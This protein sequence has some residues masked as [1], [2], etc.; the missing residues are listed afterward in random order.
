MGIQTKSTA[1]KP[2]IH[3]FYF[4]NS[5]PA[6][7]IIQE[8]PGGGLATDI[9]ELLS[10]DSWTWGLCGGMCWAAL[11][12]YYREERIPPTTTTPQ[13]GDPLFRELVLRQLDT[14]Q[15][16]RTL[17]KCIDWQGRPDEGCWWLPHSVGHLTQSE[18]WPIA[19]QKI[20]GRLPV[21]L[22]VIRVEGIASPSQNHQV[23]ATGYS[24]NTVSKLL[25]IN[26]YDPNHRYR[27]DVK[28]SM[29]L[30]QENSRLDAS[31]S[32]GERLRGFFVIPY[33]RTERV[34]TEAVAAVPEDLS[35]FWPLWGS[36]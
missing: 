1:F 4:E 15:G 27:A 26:V 29:T 28:L 3:G 12:R 8:I 16:S 10:P 7:D 23:V 5:F 18:E 36:G 9:A 11:D 24:Y 19:R 2:R 25:E 32:T 21:P 20:D 17:S 34:I 30:G 6:D 31:Q 13:R 33:D 14:L 35:W 22:C